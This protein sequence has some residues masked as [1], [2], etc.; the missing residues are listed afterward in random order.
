[1]WGVPIMLMAGKLKPRPQTIVCFYAGRRSRTMIS[2][3]GHPL[4]A[5]VRAHF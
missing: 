3:T 2:L 5:I 1:M 4:R